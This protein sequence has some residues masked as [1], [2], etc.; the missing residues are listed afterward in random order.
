L[1]LVEEGAPWVTTK[2]EDGTRHLGH[3]LGTRR[4]LDPLATL[5]LV[6]QIGNALSSAQVLGIVHGD[7][8]PERVHLVPGVRRH[9]VTAVRARV[10]GFG[11]ARLAACA[12]RDSPA[13]PSTRPRWR[14][15]AP[16]RAHDGAE[17]TPALNLHRRDSISVSHRGRCETDG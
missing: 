2:L 16:E 8:R 15:I 1:S 5:L 4:D 6:E 7:L 17:L 10:H 13:A 14:W 3:V 9:G 12:G 11:L